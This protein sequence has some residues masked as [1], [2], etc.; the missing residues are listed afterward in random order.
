[1]IKKDIWDYHKIGCWIVIPTNT[2]IKS[3]G[4]AVMGAGLA[5]QAADRFPGLASG[6]GTYLG[7]FEG[8]NAINIHRPWPVSNHRLVLMPTKH[9]W[10]NPSELWMVELVVDYLIQWTSAMTNSLVFVV[11]ALG[12]GRGG[13]RW[14]DVQ[15]VLDKLPRSRFIVLDPEGGEVD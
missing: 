12:C 10:R 1:M 13:L 7:G 2:C 15:P 6:Y 14:E 4:Q 9:D 5:K 8:C 3:N 11:P